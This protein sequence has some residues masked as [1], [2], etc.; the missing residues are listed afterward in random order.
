MLLSIPQLS[1]VAA[2]RNLTMPRKRTNKHGGHI[3]AKDR[4]NLHDKILGAVKLF[5][6]A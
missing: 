1:E 2:V 4:G 5:F 3:P 6:T